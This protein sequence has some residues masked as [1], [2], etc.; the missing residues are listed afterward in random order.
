M[1]TI[2]PEKGMLFYIIKK[3]RPRLAERRR[4]AGK[5]ET[6]V[7]G[8]GGQGTRHA[9]L[10]QD[11]GTTITAGIAPDRGETTILETIPVYD[12]M[13]ECLKEHP[14]IAVASIWRHYSTAKDA[15]L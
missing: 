7:V 12:N 2:S 15:A 9:G 6:V 3:I 5:I 14:N 10:M 11:F 4:E 8:L 1:K 13:K